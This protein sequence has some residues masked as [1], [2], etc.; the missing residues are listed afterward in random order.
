MCIFLKF[1][2]ICNCTVDES[3]IEEIARQQENRT[4]RNRMLFEL[5]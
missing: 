1:M 5:L 3:V 4:G 2:V